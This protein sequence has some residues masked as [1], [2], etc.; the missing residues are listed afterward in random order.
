M[1][2]GG[3]FARNRNFEQSQRKEDLLL[4]FLGR[5]EFQSPLPLPPRVRQAE[6]LSPPRRLKRALTEAD[7]CTPQRRV[8]RSSSPPMTEPPRQLAPMSDDLQAAFVLRGVYARVS[9]KIQDVKQEMLES[10][11]DEAE[12]TRPQE[13][14]SEAKQTA[15]PKALLQSKIEEVNNE[16]VPKKKGKPEAAVTVRG[17][18]GRSGPEDEKVRVHFAREDA[19]TLTM[20][21]KRHLEWWR[22]RTRVAGRMGIFDPDRLHL[23]CGSVEMDPEAHVLTTV[24]DGDTVQAVVIDPPLKHSPSPIPS[25]DDDADERQDATPA[26]VLGVKLEHAYSGKCDFR[27]CMRKTPQAATALEVKAAEDELVQLLSDSSSGARE[28]AMVGIACL[29]TRASCQSR[30]ADLLHHD[31]ESSVRCAAADYFGQLLPALRP[32]SAKGAIDAL[33]T[34]LQD[35]CPHVCARAMYALRT[36]PQGETQSVL[37]LVAPTALLLGNGDKF[38]RARARAV[39]GSFS[40]L[41]ESHIAGFLTER[42]ETMDG[43]DRLR[44]QRRALANLGSE[45]TL[46]S[47]EFETSLAGTIFKKLRGGNL[48]QIL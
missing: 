9:E 19:D 21:V 17:G 11:Q 3:L 7:F 15:K 6:A 5:R 42:C 13:V 25:E 38:V 32:K 40:A 23:W 35:R 12:D 4:R 20:V 30:I 2:T 36:V 26:P 44:A 43:E 29:G 39:L 33:T 46:R 45:S 8:R 14:A 34:A 47:L 22:V 48:W 27:A 41:S 16:P 28:A 37:E 24:K 10:E 1:S 18:C 31:G